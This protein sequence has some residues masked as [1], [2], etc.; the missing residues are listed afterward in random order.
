MTAL[1]PAFTPESFNFD[2]LEAM[3]AQERIK[4]AV[5]TYGD[6]LILSTSFGIQS[7]LLLHMA[8][9]V[10]PDIPVVFVDTQYLFP[11]TYR[12]AEEL[13][14]RLNLNLYIYRAP[15]SAAWQEA[16]HGKRWEQ[17]GDALDRYNLENKVEP[18]N[19]AVKE[20]GADAWLS[21]L[22]RVQASTRAE[23]P[24][25]EQQNRIAKIY[26]VID[27]SDREVYQYL[28]ANNLP[29]HPLWSENYVS[30]GDWH[31]SSPLGFGMTAEE[32]RFGGQKRECGLHDLGVARPDALD[33][34][35]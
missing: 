32:T 18:M 26:P 8:T 27:W 11:E 31:S 30:V 20:L 5:E 10:K 21:G 2:N 12:F 33:Y 7:A 23:R 15:M 29:Y 25:A 13:R 1:A 9:Q 28:K 24:A 6:R 4:W 22:R 16:L 3:T 35:I 19:R 14:E 17:G 34:Q